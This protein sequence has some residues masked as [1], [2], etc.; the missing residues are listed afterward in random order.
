DFTTISDQFSI[1]VL[2]RDCTLIL[3]WDIEI[4]AL[5][6]GEF[7]EVL[8]QKNKVFMIDPRWVT[9]ICRNQKY[10][11]KIGV[12]SENNFMI[13]GKKKDTDEEETIWGSG[14]EVEE[15][16]DYMEAIKIKIIAEEDF[17]SSFLK[18]PGCVP[19]DV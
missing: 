18:L 2:L 13:K 1:S 14:E 4:Y 5:Q 12:K 7:A 3:T 8:E 11:E 17:F 6:M 19:I 10:R 15:K 16:K 9:I